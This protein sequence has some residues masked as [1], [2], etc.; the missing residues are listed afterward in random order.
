MNLLIQLQPLHYKYIFD[1]FSFSKYLNKMNQTERIV[2]TIL[3]L[4]YQL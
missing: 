2:E 1:C 4:L 3:W